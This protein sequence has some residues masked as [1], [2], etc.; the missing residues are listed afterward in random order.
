MY[1]TSEP[2]REIPITINK[3]HHLTQQNDKKHKSESKRE[4]R[5]YSIEKFFKAM[6]K[7]NNCPVKGHLDSSSED[8][9]NSDL[10][11][12]PSNEQNVW[13]LLNDLKKS[14]I[15]QYTSD[16]SKSNSKCRRPDNKITNYFK[17][18]KF[19]PGVSTSSSDITKNKENSPRLKDTK[20]LK[21][22]IA[23][24]SIKSPKLTRDNFLESRKRKLKRTHMSEEPS[25]KICARQYSRNSSSMPITLEEQENVDKKLLNGKTTFE[26]F[27]K[28]VLEKLRNK[29]LA[30]ETTKNTNEKSSIRQKTVSEVLKEIQYNPDC[31]KSKSPE[32]T[33]IKEESEIQ[34]PITKFIKSLKEKNTSHSTEIIDSSSFFHEPLLNHS[35]L[36]SSSNK[37]H[38]IITKSSKDKTPDKIK[39]FIAKN[40][41]GFHSLKPNSAQTLVNAKV[42][43][44]TENNIGDL[45]ISICK[46]KPTNSEDSDESIDFSVYLEK[47]IINMADKCSVQKD[48]SLKKSK[49][50]NMDFSDQLIRRNVENS[51]GE[52]FSEKINTA[53][54]STEITNVMQSFRETQEDK[55]SENIKNHSEVPISTKTYS[56]VLDMNKIENIPNSSSLLDE[57]KAYNSFWLKKVQNEAKSIEIIDTDAHENLAMENASSVESNEKSHDFI[58]GTME[59]TE[60]FCLHDSY[61]MEQNST[62]E[63]TKYLQIPIT[64]PEQP[65]EI[66]P[67]NIAEIPGENNE[68]AITHF[69]EKPHVKYNLLEDEEIR[70]ILTENYEK[71]HR[72]NKRLEAKSE[73][74]IDSLCEK[75]NT[76]RQRERK[77]SGKCSLRRFRKGKMKI[78]RLAKLKKPVPHSE[79][80]EILNIDELLTKMSQGFAKP[81]P[82]LATYKSTSSVSTTSSYITDETLSDTLSTGSRELSSPQQKLRKGLNEISKDKSLFCDE[83]HRDFTKCDKDEIKMKIQDIFL[84]VFDDLTNGRRS[85]LKYRR[86][87]I[88]NCTVKD[89]RLQFKSDDVSFSVINSGIQR[90]QG[91]F[92]LILYILKKIQTLLETNTKLTK[93]ELFYQLKHLIKDQRVTDKAINSI[94]CLLD[95]GMWALNIVAQ[96]GLVFGNLKILLASG[97]TINCNVPGTLI[98]QDIGDIIEIHSTAF[99]IL[100]IEKESIFHKLI[101]E[102]LP[103]R[104]TRPFVMI[105]GKGFPDLNTQL[106]LKK[107][108][109]VLSVPVFLLVDADPHGINIMLNYRFGSVSNAHVSHHL[110]V[111]HAKWLGVF[112]SEI[113]AVN[114]KR[115]PLTVNE[116]KLAAQL[117]RTPHVAHNP[118]IADEISVLIRDGS[119]AGIEGLI[120][121]EVYLSEVYLPTKFFAKD[122]I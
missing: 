11:K 101:E 9:C 54:F 37:E 70:N 79:E 86:Q 51:A 90:S 68:E 2:E 80:S 94:S 13:N 117:L 4:M 32:K 55:S 5:S 73:S 87:S 36:T 8:D 38:N 96:K 10:S 76:S 66:I 62:K 35:R 63:L 88:E 30:S 18:V 44:T 116:A 111:P 98:P 77:H 119:K 28:K 48:V 74:Q 83:Q 39:T 112:P 108:W 46:N 97:E 49:D 22:E 42:I 7:T 82:N 53:R 23:N 40:S 118:R 84:Q 122:F 21:T 104:L 64:T 12:M 93:R 41:R 26:E 109:T 106:F 105:T 60:R 110:A 43:D 91:R 50:I 85:Y 71:Y 33:P 107:L 67:V 45:N 92:K 58:Q 114:V 24:N 95:V 1:E 20:C 103:N 47:T 120:K 14:R 25:E 65:E 102:D 115:Q 17:D 52:K 19:P 69:P 56:P 78:Y 61:Q 27:T 34:N 31:T 121:S 59:L 57:Q 99:F 6:K 29:S 89:G 3:Y 81:K 113:A 16:N 72:L 75:L 100:V 15:P